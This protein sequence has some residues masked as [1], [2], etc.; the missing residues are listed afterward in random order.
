MLGN[1]CFGLLGEVGA[2]C[3]GIVVAS[4]SCGLDVGLPMGLEVAEEY[5]LR[6]LGVAGGL[7]VGDRVL[8]CTVRCW[9]AGEICD[10]WDLLEAMRRM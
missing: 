3:V 1:E 5:G 7:R 8:S 9:E 10:C 4:V 6:V 2:V